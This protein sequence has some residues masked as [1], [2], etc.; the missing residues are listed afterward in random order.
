MANLPFGDRCRD[1]VYYR[2]VKAN[3]LALRWAALALALILPLLMLIGDMAM[4]GW[5]L[6]ATHVT[7]YSVGVLGLVGIAF[8]GGKSPSLVK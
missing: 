8:L 6:N 4:A 5:Q 1:C 3:T 7:L 2:S